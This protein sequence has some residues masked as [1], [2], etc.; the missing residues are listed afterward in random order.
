V[1]AVLDACVGLESVVLVGH[2]YGGTVITEAAPGVA[3]LECLIYIAALIPL[4][5][6]STTD[7]VQSV[8]VR[9]RLDDAIRVQGQLLVLDE[10]LAP[11]ALYN[12]CTKDDASRA[13]K[14]LTT[15]TLQSFRNVRTQ[16][17]VEATSVYIAC[18]ND[19]AVDPDVQALMA[20]RCNEILTLKSDHSPFLSHPKLL[21]DA[22][23]T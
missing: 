3:G 17:S 7:A 9:T 14:Q 10:Q 11:N 16:H 18:A 5:G 22:L 6:E 20:S 21:A 8:K 12:D 4:V 19:R 1:S 23:L 15:Q 2:S 13:V